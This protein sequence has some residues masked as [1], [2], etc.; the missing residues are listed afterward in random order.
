VK[1]LGNPKENQLIDREKKDTPVKLGVKEAE[2]I[3]E[4]TKV[5]IIQSVIWAM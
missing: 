1:G 5:V 4:G 2:Q 3:M